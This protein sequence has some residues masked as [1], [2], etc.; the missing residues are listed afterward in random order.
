MTSAR[1]GVAL[2]GCALW[3]AAAAEA[4]RARPSPSQDIRVQR[5]RE[6][7]YMLVGDGANITLQVEPPTTV[8]KHDSAYGGDQGVLVIDTGT[9]AMSDTLLATIRQF[10]TGPIRYII[11]TGAGADHVGGNERLV[12]ASG[13]VIQAAQGGGGKAP[14]LVLAHENVL[15]R[16]SAPSGRQAPFPVDA[17]PTDTYV[18]DKEVF[19]NHESIKII[20]QPGAHT[21]SDSLVYLRR[22]DVISAGELFSTTAFPPIDAQKGGHIQ[23]IIDGLNRILD[24]AIPGEKEEGGTMIVPAHGRLCDEA[25]VEFYREMVVIVRDR[26]KDGIR[27][28]RTLAQIKTAKPTLEYDRRYSK[29]DWTGDMFVEAVYR[30][31]IQTEKPQAPARP[32]QR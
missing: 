7:V 1:I 31:L 13:S 12:K 20:F 29:D 15:R 9:A 24:L 18:T 8:E 11:N 28:G 27:N 23:G 26:I 2:V 14:L 16:M 6:N 32:R 19:F 21:D 17:W 5:V 25:D 3:V 4:Q 10:S 22:S 30:D